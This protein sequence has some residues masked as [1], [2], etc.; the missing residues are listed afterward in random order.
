[1]GFVPEILKDREFGRT[2]SE[3]NAFVGFFG[4]D[5]FLA[6]GKGTEEGE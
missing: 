3:P 4:E 1:M 6:L 5:L 2:L